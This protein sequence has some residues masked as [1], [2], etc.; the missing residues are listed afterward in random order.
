MAVSLQNL[1]AFVACGA[2]WP[3]TNRFGRKRTLMVAA[4]VFCIGVIIQTVNTQSR[5]AFYVGRVIAGL[6]L[7]VAT[8]VVPMYSSEMCP[9]HLR[10]K[11]GCF[12][13]LFYTLGIFT[14][15]WVDYGVEKDLG[16]YSKQWQIPI[17]LQLIPAAL[18]GL[19]MFTLEDSVRWYEK[20]GEHFKAEKSLVWIRG[21]DSKEVQEE[22]QQIRVGVR[23]EI[24]KTE[25]FGWSGTVLA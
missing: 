10:G 4:T 18:L 22:M 6:G 19:G 17:A 1:G 15:Y 13:Q 16:N 24:K 2:A 21:G 25:G 23:I 20:R 8:V 14:S 11:I 3:I 9:A 12:F 7:G 5:P